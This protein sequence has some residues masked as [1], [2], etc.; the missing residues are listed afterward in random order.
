MIHDWQQRGYEVSILF[1]ALPSVGFAIARVTQRV[2]QGGRSV[3]GDVIRRRFEAG[4][5]NFDTIYRYL[6]DHWVLYDASFE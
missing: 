6:A 3:P 5:R 1:L 4:R 2:L